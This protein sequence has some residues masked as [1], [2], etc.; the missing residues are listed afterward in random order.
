MRAGDTQPA[1]MLFGCNVLFLLHPSQD[2]P[3]LLDR[4]RAEIRLRHYSLRTEQSYID[5][6]RRYIPFHAKR[7][8]QQQ[9]GTSNN[10]NNGKQTKERRGLRASIESA[11]IDTA[12]MNR[13]PWSPAAPPAPRLECPQG[14]A[15]Y[16]KSCINRFFFSPCSGFPPSPYR[17]PWQPG[18]V[19][20]DRIIYRNILRLK[21]R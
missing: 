5:W 3:K 18:Q 8:P 11:P 10:S 14:H 12:H 2:S 20:S 19:D 21:R 1:F 16:P 4:M 15:P 13:K 17:R 7:H 6:A 9:Q